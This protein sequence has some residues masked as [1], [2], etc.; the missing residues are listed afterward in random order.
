MGGLCHHSQ[1]ENE[2]LS[3]QTSMAHAFEHINVR[4]SATSKGKDGSVAGAII[5]GILSKTGTFKRQEWTSSLSHATFMKLQK[6]GIPVSEKQK[7]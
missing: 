1:L 4:P 3:Y 5:A 2:M 7:G 6:D